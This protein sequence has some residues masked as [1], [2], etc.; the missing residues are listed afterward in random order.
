M[1]KE[2]KNETIK[3]T[4]IIKSGKKALFKNMQTC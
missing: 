2:N 1:K 3:E 4:S